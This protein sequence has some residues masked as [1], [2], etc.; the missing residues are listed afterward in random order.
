MQVIIDTNT[1]CTGKADL[2]KQMN[3]T[4]V[5][6][7]Y[8]VATHPEWALTSK[9]ARELSQAGIKIF[10]VF[11]EY[12]KKS[13]LPLTRERGRDDGAS[14]L[15]QAKKVGQP[16][17][18]AIYFAVEGL[19]SGYTKEDLPGL[20][21]YFSGVRD[22]TGSRY[23]LGAYGDG[24]VCKT[25]LDEGFVQFTWLAA[26]STSFEGTKKFMASW[27][28]SLAQMGPLDIAANGLS[29]DLDCDNGDFGGFTLE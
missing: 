9:E 8:R 27:R 21:E 25:L 5:G 19:P 23:A 26:A 28:W 16:N 12:G 7:Y 24:I 1:N 17:G 11:E 10:V 6:R 2:L 18:S 3:V 29:V 22:A 20:R 13:Q 15:A 14:A 4:A